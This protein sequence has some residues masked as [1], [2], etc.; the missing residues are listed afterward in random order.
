MQKVI[1]LCMILLGCSGL[2]LWYSMQFQGQLKNLREMCHILELFLGEIRFGRSTL[3]ECC[4]QL[5][6]RVEEPYRGSFM[7]IYEAACRNQGEPFGELCNAC[8]TE[9]LKKLV[10][11]KADKD[12]FISCFSN[13]G[14]AEGS[15]QLR[16]IEQSKEQLE[17]RLHA[18]SRENTS[19]CR[20]A[21]SLG[22]MSG[23]LLVIL[24][25]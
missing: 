9:G 11:D 25:A 22:T 24:F 12:K 8:L 13:C 20:L 4:L 17:E 5:T 15:M 19:K 7:R 3:V 23:L 6:K 21:L 18:L 14:F 10:V 16:T 2:G 1:G